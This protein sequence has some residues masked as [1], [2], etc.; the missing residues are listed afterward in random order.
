MSE[1]D[2]LEKFKITSQ[3]V[4]DL[5]KSAG[6][7]SEGVEAARNIG[8]SAVIITDAINNILL[9]IAIANS[10]F[11]KA[12]QYFETSFPS[13]MARKAAEVPIENVGEPA[14]SIAGPALQ[15]LAFAHEDETIKELYLNLLRSSIDKRLMESVH[16]A[17][18][19]IIRQLGS[20]GAV[21]YAEIFNYGSQ[22]ATAQLRKE[23]K[24]EIVSSNVYVVLTRHLI[25]IESTEKHSERQCKEL[26]AVLDNLRR[27][28]LIEITYSARLSDPNRDIYGWV[29]H[30][31]E[32]KRN[33]ELANELT[34]KISFKQGILGLTEFGKYFAEATDLKSLKRKNY[35]TQTKR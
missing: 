23:P 32:Y 17:F 31:P 5:I 1:E 29:R 34:D 21:L 35:D 13:E 22:V 27:L 24:N 20:Y 11:S 7:S 19:D 25:E 12:K 2:E 18:V 14:L 4:G 8:K 33:L 10:A 6:Q 26:S 3:V 15:A 9:P 30:R 28:G 16:P